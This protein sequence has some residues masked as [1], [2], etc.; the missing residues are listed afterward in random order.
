MGK[1]FA[2]VDRI[3]QFFVKWICGAALIGSM[4][5]IVV[6]ILVRW[7]WNYSFGWSLEIG[8]H[9][10]IVMSLLAGGYVVLQDKHARI[11]IL[12]ASF[13]PK[14]KAM[15]DLVTNSGVTILAAVLL[16]RGSLMTWKALI[17]WERSDSVLSP[18]LFPVYI[19]VPLG[20]ALFG[21]QGFVQLIR[22][23]QALKKNSSEQ[24]E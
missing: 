10:L 21:L 16:W 23:V 7:L 11:D 22:S 8:G 15:S 18:P 6:E 12:Y 2:Y 9:L 24:S 5:M 20:G 13:S 3:N 17:N 4:A 14:V 1:I 19:L